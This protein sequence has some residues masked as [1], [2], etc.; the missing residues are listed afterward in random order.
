MDEIKN[1]GTFKN[2]KTTIYWEII[3]NKKEQKKENSWKK[4]ASIVPS[5]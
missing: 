3:T 5:I 4:S 1:R 2:S